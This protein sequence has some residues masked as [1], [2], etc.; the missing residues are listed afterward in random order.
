MNGYQLTYDDRS[1]ITHYGVLV[2]GEELPAIEA[3]YQLVSQASPESVRRSDDL[4]GLSPW[5]HRA[6]ATPSAKSLAARVTETI[7]AMDAR[8][9]WT[10][11]G[12]IGK[13]DKIV[14][15]FAAREMVLQ[16]GQQVIPVKENDMIELFQGQERPRERVIRSQTF[17]RNVDLLC[18]YLRALK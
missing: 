13:S 4:H 7:A 1:V 14:Q 12:N 16:V 10:E 6:R 5:S 18:D 15:V 2:S 11:L 17:A 3:E 8:G 9:A